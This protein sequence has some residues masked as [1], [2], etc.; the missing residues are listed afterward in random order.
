MTEVEA[1]EKIIRDLTEKRAR[2]AARTQE[3]AGER[4]PLAIAVYVD[5]DQK[6]RKRL[7]ALNAEAAT[8][9][10]ELEGLDA[11]IAEAN[12]RLTAAQRVAA[13]HEAR[14]NATELLSLCRAL[15]A[16]GA[17]LDDVMSSLRKEAEAFRDTLNEIHARGCNFPS[18][19]L[20]DVNARAA[21]LTALMSTPWK[22]EHL[23][24]GQRRTFGEIIDGWVS[25]IEGNFVS[26]YLEPAQIGASDGEAAA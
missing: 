5:G 2:V 11:A 1:V 22:I 10:S 9:S 13:E 15:S 14:A 12:A 19:A 23:A 25:R 8:I 6:A 3:I 21:L 4:N 16:H 18:Y 20:A 7:D 17:R 26:K 24:P